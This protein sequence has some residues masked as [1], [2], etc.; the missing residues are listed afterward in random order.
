[1]ITALHEARD[2]LLE[3]LETKNESI[4][5]YVGRIEQLKQE[6]S[7]QSEGKYL[8]YLTNEE[9][10]CFSVAVNFVLSHCGV[11]LLVAENL[12]TLITY[13]ENLRGDK[14]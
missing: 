3:N 7:A 10:T 9:I 5:A 2:V 13:L 11:P 4:E 14:K 6:L 12:T 1:M 8:L